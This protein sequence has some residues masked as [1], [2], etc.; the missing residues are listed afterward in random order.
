MPEQKQ[1]EQGSM[2]T[3]EEL[4]MSIGAK[5]LAIDRMNTMLIQ[6]DQQITALKA[7]I[8]ALKEPPKP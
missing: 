8:A 3:L 7:E 1:P 2:P 4:L 6:A 5:Q